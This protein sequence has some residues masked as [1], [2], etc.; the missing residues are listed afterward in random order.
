MP[1]YLL[2]FGCTG[3]NKRV[4]RI[5]RIYAL[6]WIDAYRFERVKPCTDLVTVL[7]AAV[8]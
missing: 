3:M 6:L 1:Q 8:D 4:Y 5:L 2:F 7:V